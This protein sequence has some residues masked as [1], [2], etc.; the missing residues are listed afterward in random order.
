MRL[1]RRQALAI[2]AACGI[3]AAF[4]SYVYLKRPTTSRPT[5]E[6][7][8]V[9]VLVA[10]RDIPKGIRV[11]LEDVRVVSMEQSKVPRRAIA[12][13]EDISKSVE[14]LVAVV[15]VA[16]GEVLTEDRIRRPSARLGLAF[17]VPEGMRAVTVAVD[18]VSG[19][20]WLLK[21]GDR[22]DV[23]ATFDLPD[24]TVIT[25]T[26]L[27]DVELLALGSQITPAE[28]EQEAPPE[29]AKPKP[30]PRQQTTAT[31]AVT[32]SDAQKLVLADSKGELRLALR[33][34]GD[35]AY[36]AT[37]TTKLSDMTGYVPKPKEEEK[38]PATVQ[39]QQ[40]IPPW[41][42][43][44]QPATQPAKPAG[45]PKDAVE[46]VRGSQREVIVP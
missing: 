42:Q 12:A 8:R 13:G 41:Y 5:P 25:R 30:A 44:P 39:T 31:L 45:R 9:D 22:V 15:P 16:A 21:P 29:G 28:E 36:V 23:L 17:M 2:A 11:S 26:V 20:G 14:G 27:Q 32:P 33:R 19:V 40:Q 3:L 10:A 46:V 35:T 18:E 34:A 6:E 1:T 38:E 4:L 43:P 37:K 7:P 24:D